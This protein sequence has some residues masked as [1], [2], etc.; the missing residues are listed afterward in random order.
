MSI[1]FVLGRT[2][3]KRDDYIVERIGS[4]VREDPLVDVLVVVPPQATYITEKQ[5]MHKL[6]LKGIMGVC[7]QSPARI[8]D[9]VLESTYGRT[10]CE[11]DS[12]GKSMILRMILEEERENLHALGLSARK[13]DV[14]V[15]LASLIAEL[16][17]LDIT[18]QK[19]L[20]LETGR[21]NTQNKMRDIAL[22][23]ERFEERTS[24]VFDTEDKI[25]LVI[26]HIPEAEFLKNAHL[27]IHGFD[28]YNAQTVRF[29]TALMDTAKDTLMSFY[30]ADSSAQDADVYGICNENRNKFLSYAMKNGL[31][32]TIVTQDR[33]ISPDIL[34]IEKNLYA[35]PARKAAKAKD[36]SITRAADVEE[37]T[38][39]VAAQ[40]VWLNRNYGYDYRDMAVVCGSGERY[41]PAIR[42]IFGEA[43]IPC[44]TGEKRTLVQ[45]SFCMFLL[46]ALELAKGRMKKDTL[47]AHAKSGFCNLGQAQ[48]NELQNYA[49]CNVR[50]G[51]AF[52][53][54]FS[55]ERAE[56]ARQQLMEPL[57]RLREHAKSAK[58]ADALIGCLLDYFDEMDVGTKLSA[59][60]GRAQ[61][62]GLLQ[63]AEFNGQV[64][65]KT[66]RI[67]AQAQE[68]L[69]GAPAPQ[70][71][72][73]SLLKTG[74]SSQKVGVIPPG[75][76]EVAVGDVS[77]VRL[78][79][80]KAVFVMGANDGILPN[81]EQ[82]S[83]ILA[84]FEREM[85]LS[86]LA[87]LA[88]TGNVEKQKL[89]IQ[90]I[91]SKPREKLFF[92]FVE[93]GKEKPSPL[94]DKLF[95]LFEWVRE[96]RA[97]QI[98]P[99]LKQNAY[100]QTAHILRNLAD[101]V[102]REYD[103]SVVAAVLADEEFP[104]K[105]EA[106]RRGVTSANAAANLD[107]GLAA[108]LYGE[109]KG[110]ASR[111]EQYF[112]CPYKHFVAYGLRV[113]APREYTIDQLDVGNYAHKILEEMTNRLKA[114][115]KKWA[116]VSEEEFKACFGSSAQTARDEQ[117]KYTLNRHNENILALV[118]REVFL[119]AHAI[120]TQTGQGALQP[121]ESEYWFSQEFAEGL[122]LS[123][124]IDRIDTAQM[125]ETLYFDIVDYKTGEPRFK[126]HELL[127][128]LSLQLMIYI[129]AVKTLL[130]ES[131]AFAGAN[132]L[133][134]H[135]PS[136]AQEGLSPD[137]DFDMDGICGVDFDT[138]QRLYGGGGDAV[139]T[140]S[141]ERKK[142]G[143][144][145][146]STEG[147]LFSPQEID[148][149][150]AFTKEL[151]GRAVREMRQGNTQIAP[152]EADGHT[153][154]DYCEFASIC[155]FD[156]G[157]RGNRPRRIEKMTREQAM[158]RIA[159]YGD[160]GERA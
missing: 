37:E 1:E 56:R 114:E 84:D 140:I 136:F 125:G 33:E 18:P 4:I 51:F 61:E 76:D 158:Q 75:A 124:K 132:Y 7:V 63:S 29:L 70:A 159:Q 66:M 26:D 126:L 156:E 53:Y 109:M 9:R 142:D 11:I 149:L 59:Q 44:F 106:I 108:A 78:D 21:E 43:G 54:P 8:C 98:A 72:L 38:R 102:A 32:T 101:G 64:F 95:E 14:P 113:R 91:V 81:Y 50:D 145:K 147:K 65:Q 130:G 92:S 137:G 122:T 17:T 35:Y 97:D 121:A 19:L 111:L 39:A 36:V 5:I 67:L 151:I 104:E 155:M 93:N 77:Y 133:K 85:L 83:D 118:E 107:A 12:I 153:G 148:S 143:S 119:A 144:V 134:I 31:K 55:E 116:D 135:L 60:I 22:L 110:S 152:F 28:I 154:C 138:A 112:E 58:T 3:S 94:I 48:A 49:F 47:L 74:L 103:A 69:K 46:S 45:S 80:V 25:N 128:G 27:V 160:D 71:Q 73:L 68:I 24:G 139:L 87:G 89:A 141:L 117:S 23:Y 15:Q 120:R 115:G 127:G 157:Y 41:S 13:S 79:D 88:Y 2:A 40:I 42:R 57:A 10:V 52:L 62:A 131:A 99:L 129:I 34:H 30:Y 100:A 82:S 123:G 146:K 20:E 96:N 86:Q 16:K 90:K 6:G 150:I 105:K